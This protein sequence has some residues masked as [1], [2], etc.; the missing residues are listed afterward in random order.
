[1]VQTD[2]VI[3]VESGKIVLNLDINGIKQTIEKKFLIDNGG[4]ER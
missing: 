2:I 3:K 4:K 1:M